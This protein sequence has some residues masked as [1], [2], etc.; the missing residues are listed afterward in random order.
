MTTTST[1]ALAELQAV[2]P[3]ILHFTP[4]GL[5]GPMQ[6]EDAADYQQRLVANLVLADDVAQATRQKFEQLC[7]GYVQGAL[8]YDLF[9]LVA[10][11]AQ[12]TLEQALR[13]RF[14]AHH[15]GRLTVQDRAAYEHQIIYTTYPDFYEQYKKVRG[16][17]IRMGTSNTWRGFNATLDGLLLW[18]RREGLVRGQRNRHNERAKKA[19]RNLTAHGTF[20]LLTPVEAYR[21]LSDLAE[22][23]NHLWGHSTPGG[24]L[25]PAPITRDVVAIGWDS[26]TG[27][28][29]AGHAAQLALEDKDDELTYVLVR[30][31]FSPGERDD[32]NLMEYDARHATTR[33]PAQYLWGPGSRTQ[34]IAWFEQAAPEPDTC[35]HLDQIFVIRV[36]EG[37]IH[38]PMY[39]GA[40]GALQQAERQGT[41]H[42]IR[43]DGPAEVF[44]HTRALSATESGHT[45]RGE[46]PHCPVE[47]I[48]SGDLH[49]VLRAAQ[50]AGSDVTTVVA[51]DVRTPFADLMVPRFITVSS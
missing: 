34:A 6:A 40:A 42:A 29:V 43:A 26:T 3:R 28:V 18:A 37:R 15:G 48:A 14:A 31:V 10:D 41:W 47:T 16:C 21:A 50:T 39:P 30:A 46:C 22:I 2:D 7:A 45:R 25:Y 1:H 36:Y 11:A 12:L 5:G 24:R 32:P 8:C 27:S 20:H 19:L 49:S 23:I 35:D 38:L 51:P 4:L 17:K 9:T 33:F 44:A 13:D